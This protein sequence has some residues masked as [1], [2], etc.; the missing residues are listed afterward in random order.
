MQRSNGIY[1]AST[2]FC[3]NLLQYLCVEI[4][5]QHS[6]NASESLPKLTPSP[7]T[8]SPPHL[9]HSPSLYPSLLF[10]PSPSRAKSSQPN[11]VSDRATMPTCWLSLSFRLDWRQ[12]NARSLNAHPP[13]PP[14]HC[15]SLPARQA[16]SA[17]ITMQFRV[18]KAFVKMCFMKL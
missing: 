4:N 3:L 9:S 13:P 12:P 7:A 16:H 10:C 11:R 2:P 14:S 6:A 17:V 8:H 15:P 18:L 5:T 1:C